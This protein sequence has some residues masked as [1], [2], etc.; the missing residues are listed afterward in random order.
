MTKHKDKH[1][2]D[3]PPLS[4]PSTTPTDIV[5]RNLR[6]RV[7]KAVVNE[8][9]ATVIRL[10]QLTRRGWEALLKREQE[11]ASRAAAAAAATTASRGNGLR[12]RWSSFRRKDKSARGLLVG[13]AT[14]T[15]T[16][17]TAVVTPVDSTLEQQQQQQQ[18]DNQT[19][20]L[21]QHFLPSEPFIED[22][23]QEPNSPYPPLS[24]DGRR[25]VVLRKQQATSSVERR[26]RF[27][28]GALLGRRHAAVEPRDDSD[29][30]TPEDVGDTSQH[31]TTTTPLHEAA[32]MG[33]G[34]LVRLLLSHS[35]LT[36]D[37]DAR[38][39]KGRSALHCAAGGWTRREEQQQ[40]QQQPAVPDMAIRVPHVTP[41]S[42]DTVSRGGSGV[43]GRLLRR[44][45]WTHHNN[46]NNNTPT[47]S[48]P[49]VKKPVMV[50]VQTLEL[51]RMDA[52]LALLS[53]R[54]PDGQNISTNVVDDDGRTGKS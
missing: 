7:W 22:D 3:H 25:A 46:N 19:P 17:V 26:A 11:Q 4:D 1:A 49:V 53:W 28:L 51:D 6:R 30:A 37:P 34:E 32:R 36:S 45:S 12:Q 18:D 2:N 42:S 9:A 40:Q 13:A 47:E 50:D 8:D 38:D 24:P 23:F 31:L 27:A 33:S 10:Y 43:V 21:S 5:I 52:A 41:T 14:T 54:S 48:L 15:T 39:G 20:L 29:H 44:A 16:T 35:M